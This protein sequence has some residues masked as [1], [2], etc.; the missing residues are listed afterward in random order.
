MGSSNDKC[1]NQKQRDLL[2][3]LLIDFRLGVYHSAGWNCSHAPIANQ[4][5]R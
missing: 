5:K 4:P 2:L 1:R 3:S